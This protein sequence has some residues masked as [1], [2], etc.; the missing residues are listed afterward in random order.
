[1]AQVAASLAL[2]AVDCPGSL[3]PQCRGLL[4]YAASNQGTE[5]WRDLLPLPV[6]PEVAET[7]SRVVEDGGVKIKKKGLSGGAIKAAYRKVGV[8]C[9]VFA[10]VG[11]LNALWSGFRK[12]GRLPKGVPSAAQQA[13]LDR[14]TEAAVYVIEGKDGA[15]KGA[16]PR[17]PSEGWEHKLQDARVSYHGELVCKA[18][19]L[20]LDRVLISLPPVGF[21]GVVDIL[22][23]CEGEVRRQLADPLGCLLP[24]KELPRVW[25]Q[26]QV[27]VKGSEWEPLAVTLFERGILAPT[28]EVLVV[29]NRKVLNGLFGVEKSSKVLPDGRTSQRLIMD[30]RASNSML[31]P[32]GG[33]IASLTGAAAF[34]AISLAENQTITISGDDL[35]SSFYL[36]KLPKEW[37][38]FLAFGSPISWRALGFDRDGITYMAAC[39]LPMGFASS[40][41]V[42]QHIYIDGW[43]CGGP[44]RALGCQP[45][46]RCVGTVSGLCWKRVLPLGRYIWMTR[47]F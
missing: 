8:D 34:T 14:L 20:E 7:V 19:A 2:L 36:F 27:R 3:G 22:D 26:P 12:N 40:V 25:P 24:E 32:I 33:D 43:P 17:T 30:L 42:M 21:G 23:V 38:P 44:S 35:V 46:W 6:E 9:L 16:V 37:L 1:M 31:R 4:T 47:P 18:E 45:T 10:M 39:V 28:E 11:A 5:N 15:D 13:A 41:G 29:D